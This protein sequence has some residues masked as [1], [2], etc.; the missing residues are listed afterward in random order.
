MYQQL[1]T[2]S[3]MKGRVN[4]VI[5]SWADQPKA[6]LNSL[7]LS[8]LF[9]V[10]A[11]GNSLMIVKQRNIDHTRNMAFS[12][13]AFRPDINSRQL[14]TKLQKFIKGN[15]HTRKVPKKLPFMCSL[16]V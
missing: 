8:F 14:M 11:N 9:V 5:Q 3:Y 6:S 10:G 2:I 1:T 15:D 13:L 4:N 12:I 7:Q 16:V